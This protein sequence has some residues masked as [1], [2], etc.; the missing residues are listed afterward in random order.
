MLPR[1]ETIGLLLAELEVPESIAL[2]PAGVTLRY[3]RQCVRLRPV[4]RRGLL[5]D[6][7]LDDGILTLQERMA[8]DSER[9]TPLR[10]EIGELRYLDAHAGTRHD[11]RGGGAECRVGADPA[12]AAFRR[13]QPAVCEIR[14]VYGPR[15]R[16]ERRTEEEKAQ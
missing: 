7:R 5:T 1:N 16:R 4:L 11:G 9:A 8:A 13:V 15:L 6:I 3:L 2:R 14:R 12:G 10:G